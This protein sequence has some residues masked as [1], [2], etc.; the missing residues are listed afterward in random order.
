MMPGLD[1]ASI[2]IEVWTPRPVRIDRGRELLLPLSP[3][4]SCSS[5]VDGP[6]RRVYFIIRRSVQPSRRVERYV[7][8]LN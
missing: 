6:V 5:A 3:R 1:M 4:K 8:R 2:H 7:D